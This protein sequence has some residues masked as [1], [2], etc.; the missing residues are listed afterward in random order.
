M[1]IIT[2][3]SASGSPGVSTTALGLGLAWPRPVVLVEADP[4]GGSSFLAGFYQGQSHPGL[5]ELMMANQQRLLTEA[6]PR[7]LL[8]V[9]DTELRVLPGLRSHV[10]AAAV[11]ELWGPL[12]TELHALGDDTDVIVDAG[13]LGLGGLAGTV[14]AGG[15]CLPAADRQRPAGVGGGTVMGAVAERV[16]SAWRGGVAGRGGQPVLGR[17]SGPHTLCQCGRHAASRPGR[18]PGVVTRGTTGTA[19]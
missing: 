16:A 3:V 8:R 17:R 13:R 18:G 4:T 1:A 15:G 6:L 5:V 11:R 10:Q 9:P 14:G 7:L 12:L 2:L 19:P